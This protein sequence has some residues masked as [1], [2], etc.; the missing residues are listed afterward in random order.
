[1]A[2]RPTP[3]IATMLLDNPAVV[4]QCVWIRGENA[5]RL[6]LNTVPM[7]FGQSGALR[8]IDWRN[9]KY[10]DY[11][12]FDCHLGS[13]TRKRVSLGDDRQD[14]KLQPSLPMQ[15]DPR[16]LLSQE[17]I[18]REAIRNHASRGWHL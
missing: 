10:S 16:K 13:S 7:V 2:T 15:L 12:V 17:R 5:T 6:P 11:L 3:L 14:R 1:M 18:R 4:I 8:R 9:F